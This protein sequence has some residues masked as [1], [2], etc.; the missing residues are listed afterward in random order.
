[1]RE[2]ELTRRATLLGLS[3]L[4]FAAGL[5]SACGK[6]TAP[7][8]CQDVSKL[9]DGEKT[10]RSA[11]QY[12]DKAPSADRQCSLC[13][14]WQPAPEP[15]SCGGCQLVKGPIHPNGYCTAFA[16]KPAA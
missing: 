1:M 16:A 11:L 9:S 12:T 6:K 13:S 2:R 7:D 4:P 5:L 10:S 8:S 14:F 15:T 3:A